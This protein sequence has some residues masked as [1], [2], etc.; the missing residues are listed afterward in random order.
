MRQKIY[1]ETTVTNYQL[2][3]GNIPEKPRSYWHCS[4]RL[5]SWSWGVTSPLCI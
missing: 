4:R 1:S 5:K 3:L 2:T